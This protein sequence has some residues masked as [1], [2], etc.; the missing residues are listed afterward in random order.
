MGK[1]ANGHASRTDV[2]LRL[3]ATGK[4]GVREAIASADYALLGR[5]FH[6]YARENGAQY[7]RF[8]AGIVPNLN[9]PEAIRE[10]VAFAVLSAN[11]GFDQATQALAYCARV[12]W[13]PED[14]ELASYGMVYVKAEAIRR[15]GQRDAAEFLRQSGESWHAYRL[16]L[17][18]TTLGLGL[19]KASFAVALLYPLEADVACLDTWMLKVFQRPIH[20]ASAQKHYQA[21][22]AALRKFARRHKLPSTFVAQWVVWDSVRGS[23]TDHDIFPG[24]HKDSRGDA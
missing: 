7:A 22:E 18:R 19:C 23:V 10:R 15:I 14:R 2:V 21:C 17:A 9:D 11:V 13:W 24:S 5:Q 4:N 8:A 6:S 16:R 20:H 1:K 3:M 12:Q